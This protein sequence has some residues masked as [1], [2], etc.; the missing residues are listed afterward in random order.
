MKRIVDIYVETVIDSGNYSKIELFND[1]KI[2]IS[3]SVQNVQDIS[4]VYTHFTQSFTVPAS[5]INNAIFEHFY[6]SDVDAVNNPNKRRA[7]YIEIGKTPFRAGKLQLEKS[8]IKNG[9]VDSYTV[10]FYG[11]LVSLKD[12]F[13]NDKLADLNLYA[14][15][16]NYT[17]SNVESLI[18]STDY[19]KN[20][21]FP[22]ITSGR[23]WTYDDGLSTDINTTT[24]AINFN[25][26]F[27][28]LKVARIIDAIET[29]YGINF[30]GTFFN[31]ANK[32]WDRLFLWLKNS[33]S[34]VKLTNAI[35]VNFNSLKINGVSAALSNTNGVTGGTK[36]E[37][38][39]YNYPST[40]EHSIE[41]YFTTTIPCTVYV[42]CYESKNYVKTVEFESGTGWQTL[43]KSPANVAT[44]QYWSYKVKTSTPTT[45]NS[46]VISAKIV[47]GYGGGYVTKDIDCSISD[48]TALLNVEDSVPD[49]TVADFFSGI[50]KM[51]NL[52]CYA[53]GTN[54]FLIETLDTWYAKG[55]IYDIT[56]FT[57][58]D[59]IDI[60]RVP[61]YKNISFTHEKSQSF[62]NKEYTEDN[63]GLREYGD[64][65][66]NF[67]DYENGDFE[68]KVPFEELLPLNLDGNKLCTSYCLTPKPDYKSY[69]PKPV[70]LFMDDI[71]PCDIFFNNG[72]STVNK[73][74]Y[75]PFYNE[76]AF[77]GTRYSLSFG[78]ERSVVDN[79]TLYD[80][81]YKTYYAGYL[82]NLF[83]PK[84]R[85]VNVKAHFPLSLI[86]KLKLNDRVIIRD[87]RYIINEIKSDITSGQV[88]LSLLNDFRPMVNNVLAPV[89][90]G[91]GGTV[92]T[93]V[94]VPKWADDTDVSSTY[95]GVI[96]DTTTFTDDGWLGITLPANPTPLTPT[97]LESGSDALITDSGYGIINEDY[98]QQEIPIT[99]DYIETATGTTI[100]NTVIIYQE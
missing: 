84:C 89:V 26:L 6:Q 30:E 14:Y 79:V 40:N 41:I 29:K 82:S 47:G 76:V 22:L 5:P 91:G 20:V 44:Q 18:T 11:D 8:N 53:T 51:F 2:D 98:A 77:N 97:A 56:E 57:E 24:G 62:V 59:S 31:V 3:L 54:T 25:E 33:E 42:E 83:N 55:Y 70:L 66:Q 19:T 81:I 61:L 92:Y 90:G 38:Y 32:P 28:A 99:F 80:G 15:S 7:S 73:T 9:E 65:K 63:K 21:R 16:T 74:T 52:T 95:G 13:A 50:L 46:E 10:T 39:V 75:A 1:E 86:T 45:I 4:K 96:F 49:I 72:S 36:N 87:K 94:V 60:E 12:K 27:P 37:I 34:F 43:Y 64:T 71:K 67:S 48:T 35:D 23:V 78:E 93:P 69:I 58:T 68:V 85:L 17:G 88:D 100:S